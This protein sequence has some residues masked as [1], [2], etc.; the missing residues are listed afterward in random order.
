MYELLLPTIPIKFFLNRVTN[1]AVVAAPCGFFVTVN[2]KTMRK[3]NA[4][5]IADQVAIVKVFPQKSMDL[6]FRFPKA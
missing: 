1:R 4:N 5:P 6:G 2:T 3:A